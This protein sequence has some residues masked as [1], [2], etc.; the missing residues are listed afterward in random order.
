MSG[1]IGQVPL[2]RPLYEVERTLVATAMGREPADTVIRGGKLVNVHTAE[3][4]DQVDVA[5]RSGR[6]ALVGDASRCIGHGTRIIEARGYYL[7]PGFLDGHVHV[8]SSMMTVS[9]FA[10]AV[11]PSGT[12]AIFMDPHEIANVLGVEGVRLMLEEGRGLPLKVYAT[13]PSCVP[14]APGFEDAG[15]AIDAEDIRAAM[16]WDGMVGL[17]EMMNFP[18]VLEGESGVHAEIEETLKAGKVVTG[19]YSIPDAGPDLSAYVAAGVASDHESTRPEDALAKLRLGMYAKLREGSAWR[20]VKATIKS[21]TETGIDPR[22]IVLVTDDAHPDT[23]VSL[24][25]VN[26][27]VRRAI[28][29]GVPPVRAI[30]M[31]TIN[32]AECFRLSQDLGSI[33]PGRMADILFIRDLADPRPE[34][35]MADGEVVAEDG[36]LVVDVPAFGYPDFATRSVRLARRL[37]PADFRITAPARAGRRVR[38]RVI[39]VVE[40]SALTRHVELELGVDERGEVHASREGDVAKVAVVERH[41]ASGSMAVGFVRGFGLRDGA[42]A[43]TVAH[44]SHNLLVVGMDDRDM[45]VAGNV[46]ADAGGGMVVVRGGEPLAVLPLPIAG[47]MSDRPVE[48]VRVKVD[49]LARAWGALGCTMASPF[50]TMALL[51]LPVIPELRISN[52]GI[53]DTLAFRFVDLFV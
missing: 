4:Q 15:A 20:D 42:V 17:G 40:A 50:M 24:G 30:Q 41:R 16:G 31:A 1:N 47:L 37:E 49:E 3:I 19:H 11:L 48:E 39:E 36:R 51:A 26:H 21:Y 32:T 34:R 46:V 23:L 27:V 25:H 45:A 35:V 7:V 5:V 33:A 29:E 10:R 18:G 43:S 14:A 6:V 13:M 52:R 44:D 8:E 28:E 12:T 22:H 38:A 9:Q 53:V 2:R